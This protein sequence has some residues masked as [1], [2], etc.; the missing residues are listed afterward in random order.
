MNEY[1]LEDIKIGMI[2]KFKVKITE[3]MQNDFRE[4][5]GDVNPMHLDDEFA[6][7]NGFNKKLVFGMLTA[8]FF[9]TLGLGSGSVP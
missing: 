7:K 6:N 4:I 1:K 9:S 3:K 5:T 8:S 2:E